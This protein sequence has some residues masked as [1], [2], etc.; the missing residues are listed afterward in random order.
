MIDGN[1]GTQPLNGNDAT[2]VLGMVTKWSKG[3]HGPAVAE[4]EVDRPGPRHA[5]AGA[6]TR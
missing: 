5:G 4:A 1:M 2:A 3:T 6:G